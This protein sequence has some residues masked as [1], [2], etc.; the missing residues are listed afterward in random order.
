MP[1][2]NKKEHEMVKV[3]NIDTKTRTIHVENAADGDIKT[4]RT[5]ESGTHFPIKKGESTKEALDKFVEKKRPEA[6]KEEKQPAKKESDW[7]KSPKFE[8]LTEQY[9]PKQGEADNELGEVLRSINQV[10]YRYYNDGD[11]WNKGYGK[12]TVNGAIKHLTELSKNKETPRHIARGLDNALF[13]LKKHGVKDKD[14]YETAL[15]IMMQTMEW[16]DENDIEALSKMKR[17]TE[18]QQPK[19]EFDKELWDKAYEAAKKRVKGVK[20]PYPTHDDVQSMYEYMQSDDYKKSTEKASFKSAMQ[21][22]MKAFPRLYDFEKPHLE[23][24]ANK[25]YED[26]Q[27]NPGKEKEVLEHLADAYKRHIAGLGPWVDTPTLA[28]KAFLD[29][30]LE[31]H[32][33]KQPKQSSQPTSYDLDDAFDEADLGSEWGRAKHRM[34]FHGV[35]QYTI[36]DIIDSGKYEAGDII[37][38]L[39]SNS[40]DKIDEMRKSLKK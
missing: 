31:L 17:N 14:R 3:I 28:K 35:S 11:M 36:K 13:E 1:L 22:T 10:V 4:W 6:K 19:K 18:K 38:A 27:N 5:T 16:A 40:H 26:I 29:Q 15:K 34:D 32:L 37:E 20:N 24:F 12:E 7:P 25:V 23:E 9:M 30:M 2:Y 21:T 39:E 8:K 33:N